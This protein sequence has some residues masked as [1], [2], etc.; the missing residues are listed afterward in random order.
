[1][2]FIFSAYPPF[3]IIA[4]GDQT[5]LYRRSGAVNCSNYV[6]LSE[7]DLW[8]LF[9]DDHRIWR[10]SNNFTI[11]QNENDSNCDIIKANM[12]YSFYGPFDLDLCTITEGYEVDGNYVGTE[13]LIME[14]DNCKK[15]LEE[16]IRESKPDEHV[17]MSTKQ[18]QDGS[19]QTICIFSNS[20][21]TVLNRSFNAN[22]TLYHEDCLDARGGSNR[23][24]TLILAL[25]I[26][27]TVVS[28]G[29]ATFIALFCLKR[30][31]ISCFKTNQKK[32]EIIVHQNELYGNLSIQDY[33][34]ER[35]DTNIVDRN[36]Y[37]EEEY[38][39]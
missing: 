6:G 9:L 24:Q 38:E 3:K 13:V 4:S 12:E 28:V 21:Y 22:L 16:I 2:N 34:T 20:S 10:N 18:L 1:M 25:I 35:Y 8:F 39:N 7:P 36:Q 14:N 15:R 11:F 33:F 19:K 30:R 32:Q 5:F 37:Y 23:N 31:G 27:S 26:S 29:L 17:F